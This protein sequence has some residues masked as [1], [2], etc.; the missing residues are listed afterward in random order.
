M[1]DEYGAIRQNVTTY[2]DISGVVDS[3]VYIYQ[4]GVVNTYQNVDLYLASTTQIQN[5][6]IVGSKLYKY[7]DDDFQSVAISESGN[8]TTHINTINDL[9]I[10]ISNDFLDTSLNIVAR[11]GEG[12]GIYYDGNVTIGNPTHTYDNISNSRGRDL[13]L[14]GDIR[15]KQGGQLIIEDGSMTNLTV[16]HKFSDILNIQ[17][18]GTGPGVTV[19]QQDSTYHDIVHFQDNSDNVFVIGAEGNTI[20]SGKLHIGIDKSLIS[21]SGSVGNNNNDEFGI[22][23]DFE[24]Q[25]ISKDD[26]SYNFFVNGNTLIKN[27]LDISGSLYLDDYFQMNT[28]QNNSIFQINDISG[29]TSDYI[30]DISTVVVTKHEN[31]N[32]TSTPIMYLGRTGVA[33][34]GYAEFA[35]CQYDASDTEPLVKM[36]FNLDNTSANDKT[37]VLTLTAK[38]GGYVGINNNNP[39]NNLDVSGKIRM[40]GNIEF[41]G[42]LTTFNSP[43]TINDDIS[44]NSTINVN[45]D[46]SFN[47]NVDISD[48][49]V[50]H[51]EIRLFEEYTNNF[52]G[53]NAVIKKYGKIEYKNDTA[54]S[55]DNLYIENVG[56]QN[57]V[58]KTNDDERVT[59]LNH[60]DVS[61]NHSI[62]GHSITLV[63]NVSLGGTILSSSDRRIKE[64]ITPLENCLDKIDSI[65]GCQYNRTDL[66]DNTKLHV[67][68]IAQDVEK[69]YPEIV[70]TNNSD[71]KQ[72]NYNSLIA[73]LVECVKELK[74][75]NKEL[76][77][78]IINLEN[79]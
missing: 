77:Q 48:N 64:N 22:Y 58:F 38:D 8:I 66:I 74:E 5:D 32:T 73:V 20:I 59:I 19:N 68:V 17:N 13:T 6:I 44:I 39:E 25:G 63:N 65:T 56:G 72:V 34:S 62:L 45:H 9:H 14:Y 21:G 49:L 29:Y 18:I 24:I 2:Q 31:M 36:E 53:N 26:A 67:G 70:E 60:G 15:I 79:K 35:M 40:D 4:R 33:N 10:D 23:N 69:V 37:N 61:F 47:K 50:V 43:I 3:I 7:D 55:K 71:V 75:E 51:K 42:N 16:L 30:F 41:K 54:T 1:Y 12:T 78:R 11:Q 52:T 57:I 28:I 76:K 46:I 27:D